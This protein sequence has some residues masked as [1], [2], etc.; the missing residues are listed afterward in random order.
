MEDDEDIWI[1]TKRHHS[2]FT[3]DFGKQSIEVTIL[4]L[5][6]QLCESIKVSLRSNLSVHSKQRQGSPHHAGIWHT[7]PRLLCVT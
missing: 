1:M 2:I 4:L 6:Y 3:W 7:L 5:D